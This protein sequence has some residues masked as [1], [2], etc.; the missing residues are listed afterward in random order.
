MLWSTILKK[1]ATAAIPAIIEFGK[2]IFDKDSRL[3]PSM[4][5]LDNEDLVGDHLHVGF[6]I[7][8]TAV[9]VSQQCIS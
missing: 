3:D 1:L 5:N 8:V 2:K 7:P 6:A 9:K 4:A